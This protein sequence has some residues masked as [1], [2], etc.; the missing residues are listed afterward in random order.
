[1]DDQVQALDA[2][3]SL[4]LHQEI[5]RRTKQCEALLNEFHVERG[6]RLT[7]SAELRSEVQ[8]L[9]DQVIPGLKAD[10]NTKTAAL[11]AEI[12]EKSAEAQT[13][14][15]QACENSLD[16][17]RRLVDQLSATLGEERHERVAESATLRRSVAEEIGVLRC[18]VDE[19]TAVL[20]RRIDG[21]AQ[22]LVHRIEAQG[23]EL[24]HGMQEQGKDLAEKLDRTSCT[25]QA[26]AMRFSTQLEDQRGYLSNA[27]EDQGQRFDAALDE[28]NHRMNEQGRELGSTIED[29]NLRY[30]DQAGRTGDALQA[31]MEA[32]VEE[33]KVITQDLHYLQE[34]IHAVKHG[35]PADIKQALGKLRG[36]Q[37]AQ[38][39]LLAEDSDQKAQQL[40]KHLQAE[41]DQ[42]EALA[43][44]VKRCSD[45]TSGLRYDISGL[46]ALIHADPNRKY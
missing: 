44:E 12:R 11:Q 13:Q 31:L 38:V 34:E 18:R 6:D 9:R 25:M 43:Q 5:K 41:A 32:K 10:L 27:I 19:Q 36:E 45:E 40:L 35:L 30:A 1:M 2:K 21:S 26:N 37:E 29:Q 33:A 28:T 16:R 42:R 39:R 22:E 7:S 23:Q 24:T 20:S 15:G 3:H 17:E 4:A 14:L 46:R 8:V